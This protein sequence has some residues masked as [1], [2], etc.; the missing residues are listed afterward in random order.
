MEAYAFTSNN[1]PNPFSSD[2]QQQSANF[3]FSGVTED[4]NLSSLQTAINAANNNAI[5]YS[6]L[7]GFDPNQSQKSSDYSPNTDINV[8][9]RIK[10]LEEELA[11][12]QADKEFVWSLWRQLQTANPDVTNCI[13]SVVKREKDKAELKDRKVLD[14]LQAKDDKINEL[15][16]AFQMKEKEIG[17][18][19]ERLKKSEDSVKSKA[20]E[21]RFMEMNAKTFSD[22]ELMYE[23]MLRGRDDKLDSLTRESEAEKQ[24]LVAKLRDLVGKTAEAQEKEAILQR[25][26][27]KQNQMIEMLNT[28]MKNSNENYEKLMLQL[29]SFRQQVDE[30][31]KLEAE[32]L[33]RECQVKQ[34]QNEKLRKELN[35][36]WTK[37]NTNAD[38]SA[39]Q[40]ALIRQLKQTQM[41]LQE[42]ARLQKES[43]EKE[44]SSYRSM[45][46]QMSTRYEEALRDQK[47]AA[48]ERRKT[49]S[50]S[51]E[52]VASL[53]YEIE[54]LRIKTEL[55]SQQI[56]DKKMVCDGLTR[57]IEELEEEISR[58]VEF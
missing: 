51:S 55:Q 17:E 10:H 38:H 35:E 31:A 15:Y 57:K 27:T 9:T 16:E 43:L 3:L 58:L 6:N 24:H 5:Q 30:G 2:F 19:G 32:R 25:E 41:D 36:L 52:K 49:E 34:E 13:A 48:D 37:F 1:K 4:F 8:Q 28:E 7:N 46:E 11:N 20:E 44:N 53:E 14:I 45:Y 50:G 26:N 47:K 40:E 56:C 12:T 18:I 23:Q 21:L 42:S 54:Q 29:N 33:S 22:K 39:Q